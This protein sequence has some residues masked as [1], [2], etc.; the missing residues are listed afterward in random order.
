[1]SDRDRDSYRRGGGGGGG[2][3]GGSHYHHHNNTGGED[4]NF[5]KDGNFGYVDSGS[6]YRGR[7]RSNDR[8]AASNRG[9]SKG[10]NRS[11]YVVK[12]QECDDTNNSEVPMQD[13]KDGV[14]GGR[15]IQNNQTRQSSS[16]TIN[17]GEYRVKK[18]ECD[19]NNYYSEVPMQ[20]VKYGVRGRGI[21]NNQ[22]R[23]S[24]SQ[25]INCG[26]Y[27][28]KKQEFDN[29]NNNSEVPMQEVKYGV[30]GGR[31]IQNSQTRHSSSQTMG[32]QM[33]HLNFETNLSV[34]ETTD[35][36]LDERGKDKLSSQSNDPNK[37][38]SVKDLGK[39][40]QESAITPFDICLPKRATVV[41]LKPSLLDM[42]R[43]KRNQ[44]LAIME[45]E[46]RKILRPGMIL[47]KNFL[48]INDQV[49]IVKMCQETGRGRGGFYQPSYRSGGK[50]HLKMMCFGKN[51]DPET[52]KYGDLR[53]FD[54][55]KPPIIP[56]NFFQWVKEAIEESHAIIERDSK[57]NNGEAVLPRM[58]PN[59]CIANFYSES[60]K[61][62]LHQD[63]D[64]SPESLKKGLPVVSFS[65]GD[66]AEFLYGDDRNVDEVEKVDLKS[67]DVLIFGGKSRLVFHGVSSILKDTAPKVLMAETNLRPGRLNLTFRQE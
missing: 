50:L 58:T 51:W 62:G 22:T 8:P 54:G 60:G 9:G 34:S 11:E 25:T 26:E 27:R 19:N 66:S 36:L 3:G 41:S 35:K 55:A 40:E 33:S 4:M 67:G 53:P 39:S 16:Q 32:D 57:T 10:F 56:R 1:M 2:G 64:E 46:N 12:K 5:T 44:K 43:E 18:E 63:K 47:L 45:G 65:I 52:S 24:S 49:M 59:I 21:Q 7:G 42:N 15:V 37:K 20:G 29:N 61:L 48:S 31:G 30:V 38:I 14:V 13:V 28:V 23:Y 17:R 6:R